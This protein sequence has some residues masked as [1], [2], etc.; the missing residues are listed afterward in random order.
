MLLTL[1]A[2][3]NKYICYGHSEYAAADAEIEKIIMTA[4]GNG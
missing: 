4:F 1:H 3:C 2:G